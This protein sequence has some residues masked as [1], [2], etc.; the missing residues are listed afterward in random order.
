MKIAV[1][2]LLLSFQTATALASPLG[3][4]KLLGTVETPNR[5][6]TSNPHQ[7][8]MTTSK[9]VSGKAEIFLI[10]DSA[11]F[12]DESPPSE[13]TRAIYTDPAKITNMR[14]TLAKED[15]EERLRGQKEAELDAQKRKKQLQDSL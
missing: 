13:K 14:E 6:F 9:F 10:L 3:P 12:L 15:A 11:K 8:F 7:V 2:L 5:P 1:F 4:P